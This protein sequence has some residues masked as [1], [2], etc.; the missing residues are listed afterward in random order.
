MR[1][2]AYF[3][4]DSVKTRRGTREAEEF[5]V[6]QGFASLLVALLGDR[7]T[8]HAAHPAHEV[9]RRSQRTGRILGLRDVGEEALASR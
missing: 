6:G 2:M 9:E 4:W 5:H 7:A 8:F 1:S 3:S